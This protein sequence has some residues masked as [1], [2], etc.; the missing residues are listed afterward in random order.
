[1]KEERGGGAKGGGRGKEEGGGL[2]T[3]DTNNLW[4]TGDVLCNKQRLKNAETK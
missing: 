3:V 4:K 1:M 2:V